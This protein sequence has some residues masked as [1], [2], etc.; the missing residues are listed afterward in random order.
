MDRLLELEL[1]RHPKSSDLR[2]S[3]PNQVDEHALPADT[4]P[5]ALDGKF[6][7]E[8]REAPTRFVIL[9]GQDRGDSMPGAFKVEYLQPFKPTLF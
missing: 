2:I 1:P 5:H 4:N 7:A 3:P 8:A 9:I 6:R